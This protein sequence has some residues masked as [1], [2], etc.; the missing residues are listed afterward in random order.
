MRA[1]STCAA[2]LWGAGW[3]WAGN[4]L[5]DKEIQQEKSLYGADTCQAKAQALARF[6]FNPELLKRINRGITPVENKLENLEIS[7]V[8]VQEDLNAKILGS[9]PC[10]DLILLPQQT[11]LVYRPTNQ[12]NVYVDLQNRAQPAQFIPKEQLKAGVLVLRPCKR[13]KV[14]ACLPPEEINQFIHLRLVLNLPQGSY[15]TCLHQNNLD[16]ATLK[17][18]RYYDYLEFYASTRDIV[19]FAA[20]EF[21]L[22]H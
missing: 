2:L 12:A 3:T 20:S 11:Y 17:A 7:R 13:M 14:P 9:E 4:P 10:S 16:L 5:E 15:W 8:A 19:V 21:S 6:V 22:R 18:L 1:L